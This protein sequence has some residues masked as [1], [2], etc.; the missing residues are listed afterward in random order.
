M[1]LAL[2]GIAPNL[3]VKRV[4]SIGAHGMAIPVWE[5]LYIGRIEV[6]K[7]IVQIIQTG[8]ENSSK[9]IYISN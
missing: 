5:Q 1:P 8:R 9:N 7:L 6:T 4:I 3:K 2:S